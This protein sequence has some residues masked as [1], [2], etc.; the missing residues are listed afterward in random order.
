[1]TIHT[2]LKS[3]NRIVGSSQW[4]AIT[5]F[6]TDIKFNIILYLLCYNH[7]ASATIIIIPVLYSATATDYS[8]VS[9]K[10]NDI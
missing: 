2:I 9:K 4:L 8:D 6:N 1:M 10:E 7:K 5:S 3:K